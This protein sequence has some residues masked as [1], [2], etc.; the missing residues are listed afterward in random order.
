MVRPVP[1]LTRL[2]SDNPF[3]R[4]FRHRVKAPAGK[5]K[6][7]RAQLG[8]CSLDGCVQLEDRIVPAPVIQSAVG[9]FRDGG[10]VTLT[11]AFGAVG[12]QVV[13]F[14]NFDRG[15]DGAPIQ[16]GPGSATVGSWNSIQGRIT[17]SSA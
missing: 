3:R 7:N 2:L 12:P 16:T 11:G 17:Y 9:E 10:Q 13:L 8:V 15:Q 14:D 4:L 1:L 6:G 5:S